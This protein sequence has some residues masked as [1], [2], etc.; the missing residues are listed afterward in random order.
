MCMR[1]LTT[2]LSVIAL[3]ACSGITQ[4]TGSK[5]PALGTPVGAAEIARWDISIPPSGAGLPPG[6]YRV[7]LQLMKN[8]E[9]Q[10]GG[11]LVGVKSPF[12][13]EVQRG[14]GDLVI[15]LDQKS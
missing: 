13:V 1:D 6:K 10:F 9:D 7:S 3:G 15:D 12:T 2:L 4:T 5:P 8:K 14:G 11:R